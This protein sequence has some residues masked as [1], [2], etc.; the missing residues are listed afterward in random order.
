M[1]SLL[2]SHAPAA[3]M[4]RPA[5]PFGNGAGLAAAMPVLSDGMRW[6]D[7]QPH[8]EA[9]TQAPL[10]RFEAPPWRGGSAGLPLDGAIAPQM[11]SVDLPPADDAGHNA[12]WPQSAPGG[13]NHSQGDPAHR[14]IPAP[15]VR[16]APAPSTEH[17][18]RTSLE[19]APSPPIM[20]GTAPSHAE[21][22]SSNKTALDIL[23]PRTLAP[24]LATSD[25]KQQRTPAAPQPGD[26]SRV[27]PLPQA[28]AQS[29][30]SPLRHAPSAAPATLALS[31]AAS[32]PS[33]QRIDQ[34]T[35]P[36][37]ATPTLPEACST[38]VSAAQ[39][40]SGHG[41]INKVQQT[42]EEPTWPA[43]L[44]T[45]QEQH[46]KRN[47]ATQ[48]INAPH[49]L[50]GAPPLPDT[51]RPISMRSTSAP[52]VWTAATD[53][54]QA[55]V[56]AKHLMPMFKQ[57]SHSEVRPTAISMSVPQVTWTLGATS[58]QSGSPAW[59][60]AARSAGSAQAVAQPIPVFKGGSQGG[61]VPAAGSA[62]VVLDDATTINPAGK[63][64]TTPPPSSA[65]ADSPQS[66]AAS[67]LPPAKA[68][69]VTGL[70]WFPVT[71][72]PGA[73]R[74]QFRPDAWTPAT[75]SARSAHALWQPTPVFKRS[76][77]L[78]AAATTGV[79]FA[80]SRQPAP[81]NLV[82]APSTPDTRPPSSTS[83]TSPP[84]IWTA[85]K[86]RAGAP[87]EARHPIPVFKQRSRSTGVPAAGSAYLF[88]GEATAA[89]RASTALTT[90]P[91]SSTMADLAQRVDADRFLPAQARRTAAGSISAPV[92]G[93]PEATRSQSRPSDWTPA[94]QNARPAQYVK[95]LMTVFKPG[96]HLPTASATRSQSASPRNAT[97]VTRA[98][99]DGSFGSSFLPVVRKA[100]GGKA[101]PGALRTVHAQQAPHT[102]PVAS[103]ATPVHNQPQTAGDGS[104]HFA[105]AAT[106]KPAGAIT[107][108]VAAITGTPRHA[109]G[110]DDAPPTIRV[111][112]GRIRIEGPAPASAKAARFHRPA[113]TLTLANYAQRRNGRRP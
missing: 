24:T 7:L 12:T 14:S 19:T 22:A 92:G 33:P 73:T 43:Q 63:A 3:V 95:H 82:S 4:P 99:I 96:S 18:A 42:A 60:P 87:A 56:G 1:N 64:V 78:V 6:S 62:P 29:M 11:N 108:L 57:L 75:R 58:R 68:R 79:K 30:H 102:L 106:A 72:A 100:Y 107:P 55:P 81:A 9:D 76:S 45:V 17:A 85:A 16:L 38:A 70:N 104:A 113:P 40:T 101:A 51:S 94:A 112:I 44:R 89:K 69:V 15:V 5:A 54:T 74:R 65:V 48:E 90:L 27:T 31:A 66:M 83:S 39:R 111:S 41:P 93:A 86:G 36:E 20:G 49:I 26:P 2:S 80:S 37:A 84:F 105:P 88:R 23:E 91:R 8:A 109:G 110:D 98:A 34:A 61:V 13:Q 28:A 52:S 103:R 53:G 67:G 10:S 46:A 50:S 32:M 47:S 77:H 59:T 35:A 21:E 25:T 97:P 71:S